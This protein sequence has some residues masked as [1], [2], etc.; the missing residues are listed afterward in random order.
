MTARPF[1]A[2]PTRA[3]LEKLYIEAGL[4]MSETADI[5]NTSKDIVSAAL[6]EYGIPRRRVGVKRSTLADIPLHLLEKN[7]DIEG[8][9]GHARRLGIDPATL[10]EHVQKRRQRGGAKR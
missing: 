9:R 5:L 10:A 1:K 4:S 2:R 7:I 3:A 6:R 8:L